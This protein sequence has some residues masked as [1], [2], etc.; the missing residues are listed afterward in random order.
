VEIAIQVNG[1]VRGQI[2][3]ARDSAQDAVQPQ[4]QAV[5]EKWLEG[6]TIQKVVF[7]PNRLLSFVIL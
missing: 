6:K 7:V 3:V 1:K 2:T 4:A 5:I